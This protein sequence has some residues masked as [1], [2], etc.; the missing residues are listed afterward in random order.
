[1]NE[2]AASSGRASCSRVSPHRAYSTLATPAAIAGLYH[3]LRSVSLGIRS[4]GHL[5]SSGSRLGGST[6]GSD[7]LARLCRWLAASAVLLLLL[8][9]A[10]GVYLV[11]KRRNFILQMR[12]P[13]LMEIVWAP[14]VATVIVWSADEIRLGIEGPSW[15]PSDSDSD[16]RSATPTP[17]GYG[18]MT[19]AGRVSPYLLAC[20]SH[21]YL[22]C[23][24][25]PLMFRASTTSDVHAGAA[26]RNMCDLSDDVPPSL[27]SPCAPRRSPFIVHVVSTPDDFKFS[28]FSRNARLF[29]EWRYFLPLFVYH[30]T[31]VLGVEDA[32][33]IVAELR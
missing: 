30:L 13:H 23:T 5:N 26:Q 11:L 14:S 32:L 6:D 21:L 18:A 12:S 24:L 2:W 4:I 28:D 8:S 20:F 1:M 22:P 19:T 16:S 15:W 31:V 33:G 10:C 25:L 17:S 9:A 7:V 29:G 27:S 3:I